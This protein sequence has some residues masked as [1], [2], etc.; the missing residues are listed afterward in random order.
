M[1]IEVD[2]PDC[3]GSGDG[4]RLDVDLY[5]PCG[6]CGGRGSI[7]VEE[8]PDEEEPEIVWEGEFIDVT[9]EAA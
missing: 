1:M 5:A 7:E 6:Y 4:E 3:S 9:E 8:G 2:C